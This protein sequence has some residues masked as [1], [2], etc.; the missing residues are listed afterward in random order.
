MVDDL[1]RCGRMSF[2]LL[3]KHPSLFMPTLCPLISPSEPILKPLSV[4]FFENLLVGACF[5]GQFQL[6]SDVFWR[7]REF[8]FDIPEHKLGMYQVIDLVSSGTVGACLRILRGNFLSIN[9]LVALAVQFISIPLFKQ[10]LQPPTH[11]PP[12]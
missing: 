1:Y 3:E 8:F 10:S 11:T 2:T 4:L 5:D 7:V 6:M 9:R 12:I